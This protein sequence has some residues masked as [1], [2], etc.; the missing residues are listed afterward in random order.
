MRTVHGDR[1][2]HE[3][4]TSC[5]GEEFVEHD[6]SL[7]LTFPPCPGSQILI[8]PTERLVPRLAD[9]DCANRA[10]HRR[11][12]RCSTASQ[13]RDTG[14]CR[15]ALHLAPSVPTRP[16]LDERS[17]ESSDEEGCSLPFIENEDAI[18]SS[19]ASRTLLPEYH[20]NVEKCHVRKT[21]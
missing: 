3:L 7:D 18:D 15:F 6:R 21:R 8:V 14:A 20:A 4:L 16:E 1:V 13:R 9:P 10:T 19:V 5:S 12:R 11:S 2:H 17:R